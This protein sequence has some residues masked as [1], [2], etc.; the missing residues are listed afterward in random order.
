MNELFDKIYGC[1]AGS[2]IG[3]AMGAAVE[4]WSVEQISEKYGILEELVPYS[5][6]AKNDKGGGRDRPPGTTEDGIERQKLMVTA[7]IEKK[8]RISAEDLAKVWIRDI[9]PDNFGVQMQPTDAT[10]YRLLKAGETFD[11]TGTPSS[12]P[13]TELGR[14]SVAPG[15]IAFARSCHPL[16][17]INAANPDQAF[18]DAFEIGKMYLPPHDVGLYW[19]AAVAVAIAE[20]LKPGATV[21]SVI[22]KVKSYLPYQVAEELDYGLQVA[23]KSKDVFEMRA[24]L[25]QKYCNM[26]GLNPMSK[27]HEIVTKGLSIFYKTNGNARDS[28]VGSVNFGRDTDC[29]GAVAG[30]IAGSLS[31]TESIPEEWIRTVDKATAAMKD[32]YSVSA[33]SLRET[34]QG[35]YESLMAHIDRQRERIR[36]LDIGS[37]P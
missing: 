6:Y 5:H 8:D 22:E 35:L 16:G 31:G 30:G 7:I 37:A 15:T 34:S 1:I 17:I 21:E 29:L 18:E 28:I 9:N 23:E 19:S 32:K 25:N 11:V 36:L 13:P 10:M 3:S 12:I 14:Y 27:A 2:N 33:L 24:P 4:S 26:A 20:A